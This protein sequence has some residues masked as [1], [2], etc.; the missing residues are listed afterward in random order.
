[1]G[2]THFMVKNSTVIATAAYIQTIPTEVLAAAARGEID[3]N[4]LASYELASRGLDTTGKW[5]GY[6]AAAKLAQ[7]A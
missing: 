2:Y 3:L 7:Q 4:Q 1:M 5:V 6:P